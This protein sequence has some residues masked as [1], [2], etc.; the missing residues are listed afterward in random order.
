MTAALT[1]HPQARIVDAETSQTLHGTALTHAIEAARDVS[2]AAPPGVQFAMMPTT[3]AAIVSYLGALSAGRPVLL[4]DPQIPRDHRDQLIARFGPA[5]VTGAEGETPPGYARTRHRRTGPVWRRRDSAAV[6]APDPRLA[7][8]LTTSGSTGNPRLVRLSGEA[9]THNAEAIVSALEIS[10][11]D[12]AITTLP[13]HY[14]FGLSVL[15]SHL[16]A[17]STLVLHRG[18]LTE[19]DFWTA[20]D[21]HR[22]TS[23]SAVP[24]QFEMLRRVG[25]NPAAHPSVTTL[26]AAGGRLPPRVATEF[27]HAMAAEGGRLFVMYGATEATARMTVLP[28]HRLLDKPHSV[29]LPVP[30]GDVHIGEDGEV[31]YTGP[32]VM[33]GYAESAVDLSRGDELG[34][35][36]ATGDLGDI[37]AEGYLSITGRR[38]RM[39]KVFGV[40]INLDDVERLLAEAEPVVGPVAALPG[41]DRLVLLVEAG[42]D[43]RCSAVRATVCDRLGLHPSGVL[44]RGVDAL[45]LL[46]SGKVDYAAAA[47]VIAS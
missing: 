21:T 30:G 38:K 29:G 8:L 5:L 11:D 36:L 9:V 41:D 35:V 10:A 2:V 20:V 46:S 26:A 14:T 18:S 31:V 13:L 37:D 23:L 19:R 22:V 4:L 12:V 28:P 6:L 27:H 17:G 1:P 15:H 44:T 24:Y 7:L 33:M 25:F 16:L 39:A 32:N 47:A 43:A 42:D 45:P 34:G 3:P 40:R